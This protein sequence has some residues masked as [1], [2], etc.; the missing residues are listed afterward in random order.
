MV[1]EIF[2]G[3][4]ITSLGTLQASSPKV[5]DSKTS[6]PPGDKNENIL[7]GDIRHNIS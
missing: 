3:S 5:E 6:L 1:G 4:G 2:F 7:E